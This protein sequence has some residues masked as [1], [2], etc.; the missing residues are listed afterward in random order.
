M[1]FRKQPQIIGSAFCV[2]LNFV[3]V[4]AAGNLHQILR[5]GIGVERTA[6]R[7]EHTDA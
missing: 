5:N 2:I 1:I 4:K 6:D 3:G 7:D